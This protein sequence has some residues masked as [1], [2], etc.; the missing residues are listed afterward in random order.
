MNNKVFQY[1]FPLTGK[2]S[3]FRIWLLNVMIT[4]ETLIFQIMLADSLW[5]SLVLRRL[6]QMID[7]TLATYGN[8]LRIHQYGL[9]RRI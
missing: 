8:H 4:H 6:K 3:I 5:L 9:L 1:G 2:F 7:V